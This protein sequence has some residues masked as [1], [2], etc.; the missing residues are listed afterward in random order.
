VN[1][2][3]DPLAGTEQTATIDHAMPSATDTSGGGAAGNGR[4][5]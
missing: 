2:V 3:D 1:V 5:R 4:A